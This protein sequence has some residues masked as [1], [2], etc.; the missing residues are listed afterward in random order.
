[1]NSQSPCSAAVRMTVGLYLLTIAGALACSD[2]PTGLGAT[3]A[4][5][6]SAPTKGLDYP[7]MFRVETNSNFTG[8]EIKPGDSIY[9]GGLTAGD[10]Q[11]TLTQLT[12][13]CSTTQ[14]PV[15]VR[16]EKGATAHVR[17]D[18]SC[19][20]TSGV[21]RV[22]LQTSGTDFDATGYTL[23]VSNGLSFAASA[24]G[25]YQFD[26]IPGGS[27]TL[28]I[29]DIAPNCS[30]ASSKIQAFTISLGGLSRDTAKTS[31]EVACSRTEKFAF[32]RS[33]R[34]SDERPDE[35]HVAYA[36]GS[37]A[38]SI[39]PG[40]APAWSPNGSTLAFGWLDCGYYYYFPCTKRGLAALNSQ[41]GAFVILTNDST[42][43]DPAWRPTDGAVIAFDRSSKLYLM[44]ATIAF[45]SVSQ[46]VTPQAVL[47]A[48][49]PS[50]SPDATKLAFSCEMED[51]W[52]D[53][54]VIGA[55]GSGLVRLT[56]DSSADASP[57]WSPDGNQ[58][59]FS[60]SDGAGSSQIA[61]V[62][63]TGSAITRLA[64]AGKSPAWS[65]DGTKILFEGLATEKGIFTITLSSGVV[66]RLTIQDD[67]DP[68]WRP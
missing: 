67:H 8:R 57:A 62:A 17:F 5:W 58:I 7:A 9:V 43:S 14:N 31:F 48:T 15:S 50:W 25:I 47:K 21:L 41:T 39:T 53:I 33:F 68:A 49:Q 28:T 51:G 55:D 2:S 45:T 13:N 35:I 32:R 38:V 63:S 61:L 11:V 52:S 40:F 22:S 64:A 37:E 66:T 1:M 12:P 10:Y 36:D 6:I 18:I 24:N 60:T 20:A 59:A 19:V 23:Q 30:L 26:G 42:D 34:A 3:G 27:H 29:T 54:C 16:I 65:R 44:T 46:L 4:M 56:N